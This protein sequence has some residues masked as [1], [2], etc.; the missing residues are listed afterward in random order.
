M[1]SSSQS[2]T[3]ARLALLLVGIALLAVLVL[4]ATRDAGL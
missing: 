3:L 1:A 2:P 4:Q